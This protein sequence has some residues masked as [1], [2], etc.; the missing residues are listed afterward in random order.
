MSVMS[1]TPLHE[2]WDESEFRAM[3]EDGIETYTIDF[4]DG[5]TRDTTITALAYFAR[6]DPEATIVDE[7]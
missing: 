2:M 4:E 5:P 1:D 6:L 3:Q 7:V